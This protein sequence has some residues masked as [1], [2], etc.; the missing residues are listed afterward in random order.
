M[1]YNVIN[2]E[3]LF[4][5]P[6]FL[7]RDPSAELWQYQTETCV[8]DLFLYDDGAG[9]YEVAHLE[10]RKAG[11]SRSAKEDCLRDI[12]VNMDQPT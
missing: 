2:L 11:H 7:R 6:T 12:I 9:A 8:L 10:F 5:E 3:G 1:G 4:G